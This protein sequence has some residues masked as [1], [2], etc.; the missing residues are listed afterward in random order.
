MNIINNRQVFSITSNAREAIFQ[1][2]KSNNCDKNFCLRIGVKQGGCSGMSYIMC[3]EHLTSIT[4]NDKVIDYLDFQIVC[5]F[6]SLL[7]LYG[8]SLDYTNQ[9]VGGGFC[10]INPNASRTCGCGKSFTVD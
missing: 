7:F 4:K 6:K 2:K 3:I 8:L 10:F 5:D 1:L 9:L